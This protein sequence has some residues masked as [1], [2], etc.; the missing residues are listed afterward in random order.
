VLVIIH[1]VEAIKTIIYKKK[2]IIDQKTTVSYKTLIM[3]YKMRH[4]IRELKLIYLRK[5]K[6]PFDKLIKPS[7]SN[8]EP[9]SKRY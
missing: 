7:L 5:K 8:G 2:T 4:K 9:C 3:I 1:K 6:K